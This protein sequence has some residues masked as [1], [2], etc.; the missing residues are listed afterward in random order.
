M[1]GYYNDLV[2]QKSWKTLQELR[3]NVDFV[4][5]GGWAIYLYTH[6]LKSKDIDL[7]VDFDQ[8]DKLRKGF[9]VV[10]NERLRKYEARREEVQID[11]YLGHYKN[12]IVTGKQ[13]GRAHV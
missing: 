5:I 12:V 9:T 13:I 3:G 4:L 2:T 7:I 11:V 1:Q 10:K 6:S 8:L